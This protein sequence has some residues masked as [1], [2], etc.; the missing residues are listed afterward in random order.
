V[1]EAPTVSVDEQRERALAQLLEPMKWERPVPRRAILR[2][3][4]AAA[5]AGAAGPLLAACGGGTS[6]GGGDRPSGPFEFAVIAP[7][8][9]LLASSWGTFGAPLRIAVDEIN[10]AGGVLGRQIKLMDFD[11]ESKPASE[12]AVAEK[13]LGEGIDFIA[14]P[15]GSSASLPSLERTKRGGALQGHWG[16]DPALTDPKKYPTGYLVNMTSEQS[17]RTSLR[18]V[19]SLGTTK[20]AILLANTGDG[21]AYTATAKAT[22]DESGISPVLEETF[23]QGATNLN[24]R[25]QK[26]K[27]AGADALLLYGAATPDYAA[28]FKAIVDLG[29]EVP[30]ASNSSTLFGIKLLVPELPQAVLSRVHVTAY[31][32]LSWTTDRPI[33]DKQVQLL[34]KVST[35]PKTPPVSV[36]PAIQG[37][38]Y[39]WMYLVK[40]AVE[41][42]GSFDAKK[43]NDAL[44]RTSGYP[45]LL[46]NI[47]FTP[48]SHA[49]IPDDQLTVAVPADLKDERSHGFLPQD[50]GTG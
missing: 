20:P 17:A 15:I 48:Q 3:A 33:G 42:A 1:E 24:V 41:Q 4:G 2:L 25:V 23:E 30:I 18:K 36:N 16:A 9:G 5:M 31:R 49:G 32:N 45:G 29:W 8:T 26:A 19:L 21:R 44:E 11:D 39:D 6:S 47:T 22:L 34:Q 43:V 10:T 37:P 13:I 46:A 12:P 27:N 14:G 40:Q 38:F 35:A 7:L 50:V 28:I